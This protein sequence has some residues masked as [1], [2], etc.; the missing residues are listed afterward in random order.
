[1]LTVEI[2][3]AFV[4]FA[5]KRPAH[6]ALPLAYLGSCLTPRLSS[7]PSSCRKSL[8]RSA[9]CGSRGGVVAPKRPLAIDA[10]AAQFLAEVRQFR[11]IGRDLCVA[12]EWTGPV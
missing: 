1:M 7:F 2:G 11:D 3:Y 10:N 6:A 8:G 12:P 5:A 4:E 9:F